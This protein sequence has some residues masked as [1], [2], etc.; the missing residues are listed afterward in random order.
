MRPD[1]PLEPWERPVPAG[2]LAAGAVVLWLVA[3]S[4]SLSSPW[5][6]VAV[7]SASVVVYGTAWNYHEARARARERRRA[8]R[9]D[10]T[11]YDQDNERP[12][13]IS[14]QAAPPSEIISLTDR[15]RRRR[16]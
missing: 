6:I 15:R 10:P 7:G 4:R 1:P 11:F 8:P 12:H 14:V 9:P 5:A 16:T 2:I 3:A 13:Q